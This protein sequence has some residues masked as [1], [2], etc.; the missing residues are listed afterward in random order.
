[1]ALYHASVGK[2]SMVQLQWDVFHA[3]NS[4]MVTEES[5]NDTV[6]KLGAI[7][8]SREVFK[9]TDGHWL[10]SHNGILGLVQ[11]FFLLFSI[12]CTDQKTTSEQQRK[13]I[14]QLELDSG[15]QI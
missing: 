3:W 7:S 11:F 12:D 6:Q 1:M 15:T 8:C 14:C 13:L 10:F 4:S 9:H 5:C 2:D